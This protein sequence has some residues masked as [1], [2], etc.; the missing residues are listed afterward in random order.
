MSRIG[1]KP[2][3]IPEKTGVSVLDRVVTVKGPLGQLQVTVHSFIEV[4]IEGSEINLVL[5]KNTLESRALWG[6]YGSLIKSM[7]KGVNEKF[8]KVLII[9]GI[10]YKAEVKGKNIVFS[11][12]LS[13]QVELA[14]PEGLEVKIEKEKIN[15]SGIDKQAVGQLAAVIRALK[16]PEP[17][18]GKGI[19]YSDEVVKRKQG[20]KAA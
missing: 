14:I 18:K 12:G 19:R 6:T 1:K 9:E 20:K 16:K 3:S 5:K 15:I 4:K 17:Y 8:V 7:I 13:H 10:G 2:I 11:L